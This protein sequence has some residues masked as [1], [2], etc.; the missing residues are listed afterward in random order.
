M[1]AIGSDVGLL[2]PFPAVRQENSPCPVIIHHFAFMMTAPVIFHGADASKTAS[3]VSTVVGIRHLVV[4]IIVVIAVP[5]LHGDLQLIVWIGDDIVVVS[6]GL[7]A[8]I[9]RP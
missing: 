3:R 7:L 2:H 8:A 5:R 4:V 6:S 1:V 9:S